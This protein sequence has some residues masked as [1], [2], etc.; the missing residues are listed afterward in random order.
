MG[1]FYMSLSL[2]LTHISN[3][4]VQWLQGPDLKTLR[5]AA[6][7]QGMVLVYQRAQAL[8]QDMGVNLRR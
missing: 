8:F 4:A 5:L 1:A 2:T 6:P 3:V 7:R